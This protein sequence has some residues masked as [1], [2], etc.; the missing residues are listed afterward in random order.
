VNVGAAIVMFLVAIGFA[1]AAAADILLI[2]RVHRIYRSSGASITK[3]KEEFTTGVMSNKNVQSF[4][5]DAATA[6]ARN[7]MSNTAAPPAA[8]TAGNRF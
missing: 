6:A 5:A 1:S 7:A 2:I 8:G 4:A 3:A